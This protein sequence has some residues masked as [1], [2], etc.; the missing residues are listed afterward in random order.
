M[1]AATAAAGKRNETKRGLDDLWR[2]APGYLLWDRG[3]DQDLI[4]HGHS[5]PALPSETD[6]P[7][8]AQRQEQ[9][10]H[11]CWSTAPAFPGAGAQ[12]STPETAPT[13]RGT[14]TQA[15]KDKIVDR[16]KLQT[17]FRGI[18]YAAVLS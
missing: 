5:C 6:T 8:S 3:T 11:C 9:P 15:K 7:G 13:S 10:W 4:P 16:F 12:G 14:A 18:N 1:K 17:Y 2:A